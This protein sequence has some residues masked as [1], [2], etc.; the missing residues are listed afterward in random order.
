[1]TS[2]RHSETF[3]HVRFCLYFSNKENTSAK[4]AKVELPFL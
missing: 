4:F 3:S 2:K 1:M